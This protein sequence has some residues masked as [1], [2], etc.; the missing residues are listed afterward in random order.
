MEQ[1]IKHELYYLY[2]KTIITI[3]TISFVKVIS[4]AIKNCEHSIMY[5]LIK[6]LS[7]IPEANILLF[8]HC[9]HKNTKF[10]KRENNKLLV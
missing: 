9:S 8:V 3:F 7:C 2:F 1:L 10:R 6:S 5:K 4:N